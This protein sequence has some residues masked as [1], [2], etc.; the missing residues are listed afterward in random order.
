MET[1]KIITVVPQGQNRV[2]Q[3]GGGPWTQG[4]LPS[5]DIPHPVPLTSH[6]PDEDLVRRAAERPLPSTVGTGHTEPHSHANW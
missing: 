6:A 5:L 3:G 1:E 4:P 2:L